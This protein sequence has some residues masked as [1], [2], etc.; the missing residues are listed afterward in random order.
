MQTG[1]INH[2][3]ITV[4]NL[5]DSMNFYEPFLSLLGY[6]FK[7][8]F[9]NESKIEDS[10][11]GCSLFG[12]DNVGTWINLW[13]KSPLSDTKFDRYNVGLHHLAFHTNTKEEL[14][15]VYHWVKQNKD[16]QILDDPKDYPEYGPN[17]HSFF[18][19]EFNGI[20]LEIVTMEDTETKI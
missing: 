13:Q 1:S 20:K 7:A 16:C 8:M 12:N 10:Y 18:F 3:A 17:Y 11:F 4:F 5:E 9:P 19:K 6:Q 2:V 14:V 15:K